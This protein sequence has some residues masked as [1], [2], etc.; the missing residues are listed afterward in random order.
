MGAIFGTDGVRGVA[1]RELTPELAFELGLIVGYMLVRNSE[2]KR[3]TVVIGRDTRISGHMLEAAL[4]AGLLSAGADAVR[5]GVIPTPGVAYV[6]RQSGMDAGVMISASH[7]P[8]EDNGIKF[9]GRD[10]FKMPDA[11]EAEV[12]SRCRVM[13]IG[14]PALRERVLVPCVMI[15]RA[16]KTI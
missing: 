10:G 11:W 6:T 16:L 1:N 12:E 3:P 8:V 5:L 2:G 15:R 13:S 7:N 4:A 9:F 14:F